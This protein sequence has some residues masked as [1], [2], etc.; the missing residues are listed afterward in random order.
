[1]QVRHCCPPPGKVSVFYSAEHHE[2]SCGLSSIPAQLQY[3]REQEKMAGGP[4]HWLS[5]AISDSSSSSVF[6]RMSSSIFSLGGRPRSHSPTNLFSPTLASLPPSTL[7]AHTLLPLSLLYTSSKW[8][9]KCS[10]APHVSRRQRCR[11]IPTRSPKV[12][13]HSPCSCHHLYTLDLGGTVSK[14]EVARPK[15]AHA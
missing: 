3:S 7:P 2:E 5:P 9:R 15:V 13:S 8:R 4:Q 6:L 1:M 14:A 10:V 12:R 11:V